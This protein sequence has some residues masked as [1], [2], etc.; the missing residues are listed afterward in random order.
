MSLVAP[1]VILIIKTLFRRSAFLVVQDIFLTET[2]EMADVVLPGSSF[3]EKNGT[4]TS[5]ERC[6]TDS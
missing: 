4:F 2:A 1:V 6:A 5:T 3:A